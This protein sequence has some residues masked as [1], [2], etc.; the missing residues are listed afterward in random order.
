[1][2]DILSKANLS[3]YEAL[4][5]LQRLH[6]LGVTN[7]EKLSALQL[8]SLNY[9]ADLSLQ[10]LKEV[11]AVQNPQS[12][13]VYLVGQSERARAVGEKVLTDAKQLIRLG[14]EFHSE[15]QRVAQDSLNKLSGKAA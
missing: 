8:A 4:E 14:L 15:A 7:L 12:L 1:M 2:N 5:T 6:K 10:Q 9:Y 13:Q 11:L 3:T